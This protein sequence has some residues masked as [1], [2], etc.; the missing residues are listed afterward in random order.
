MIFRRILIPFYALILG[1]CVVADM[2][3]S[4]YHY[5]PYFQTFQKQGQ[6]GHT[7]RTQRKADLYACG[8]DRNVNPDSEFWRRNV[9]LNGETMEQHDRR[10]DKLET[11]MENKGYVILD[12]SSC[13][14]VK[15]PTG[16]CN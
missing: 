1:G 6:M 9:L 5:P 7:D 2:D 8:V 13:G 4:N 14:P 10:I 12:P 3:S 11:C 15:A 16:K